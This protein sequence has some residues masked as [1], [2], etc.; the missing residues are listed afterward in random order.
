MSL[1][2]QTLVD[3]QLVA[4]QLKVSR[5]TVQKWRSRG[6]LPEPDY[7]QLAN[8]LWNWETIRVWAEQTGRLG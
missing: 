4:T 8:P 2:P 1:S 6:V 7:P 3:S 5:D